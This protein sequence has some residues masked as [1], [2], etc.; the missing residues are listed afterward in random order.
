MAGTGLTGLLRTRALVAALICGAAGA[1]VLTIG[2]RSDHVSGKPVAPE[3]AEAAAVSTPAPKPAEI[4]PPKVAAAQ[5]VAA[6]AETPET[7]DYAKD[8][9]VHAAVNKGLRYLARSQ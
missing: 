3:A 5:P 7:Y 8:E 9:E 2:A 4:P 6:D 1:A